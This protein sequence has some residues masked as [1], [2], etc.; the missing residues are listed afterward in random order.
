MVWAPTDFTV[1]SDCRRVERLQTTT[2]T[3]LKWSD[4]PNGL[5]GLALAK[6]LMVGGPLI[7]AGS[8]SCSWLHF[9][10][11]RCLPSI[12]VARASRDRF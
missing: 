6:P 9:S 11:Q 5:P 12:T 8:Y 4:Q 3:M 10:W 1:C 7:S 2:A